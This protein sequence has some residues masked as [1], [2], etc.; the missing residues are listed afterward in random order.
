VDIVDI[1]VNV[2]AAPATA[3]PVS[4]PW[5]TTARGVAMPAVRQK[6]KNRPYLFVENE[7][8]GASW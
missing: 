2:D 6:R 8:V 1:V 4:P 7:P 5:H 3:A